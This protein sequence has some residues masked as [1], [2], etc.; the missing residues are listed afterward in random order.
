MTACWIKRYELAISERLTVSEIMLLCNCS[1][2]LAQTIRAKTID[3]CKANN[4]ELYSRSVPTDIV[5][6]ITNRDIDYFYKKKELESK[7]Y[8]ER[9]QI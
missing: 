1:K 7:I 9:K 4:I 6:K 8:D 3:Y 5:L 2:H